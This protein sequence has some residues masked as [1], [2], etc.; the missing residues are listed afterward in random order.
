MKVSG[1]SIS[2]TSMPNQYGKFPIS[3]TSKYEISFAGNFLYQR[4]VKLDKGR[5]RS[6]RRKYPLLLGPSHSVPST[7]RFGLKMSEIGRPAAAAVIV[8]Y[9]TCQ[10]ALCER[11]TSAPRTDRLDDKIL[12]VE[13]ECSRGR[14]AG[15]R[16]KSAAENIS[17]NAHVVSGCT[18]LGRRETGPSITCRRISSVPLVVYL[19]AVNTRV[20]RL[21]TS[22]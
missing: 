4:K 21:S 7:H 19:S 17:I 10:Y 13:N 15:F 2:H 9:F 1:P 16:E 6:S 18:V 8:T 5:R 20:S 14:A 11:H 3:R 22:G 12:K